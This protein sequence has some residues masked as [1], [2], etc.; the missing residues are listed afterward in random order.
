MILPYFYILLNFYGLPDE[1]VRYKYNL[2]SAR[3]IEC[4]PDLSAA[5]NTHTNIL[6]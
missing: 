2:N 3:F 5:F 4:F 1:I 6:A